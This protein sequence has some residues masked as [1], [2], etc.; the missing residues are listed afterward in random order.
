MRFQRKLAGFPKAVPAKTKQPAAIPVLKKRA[1]ATVA[2]SNAAQP[3]KQSLPSC[4]LCGT[5]LLAV[6][7]YVYPSEV[8]PPSQGAMVEMQ[9][10][11]K[12]NGVAIADTE[13]L[14]TPR[15]RDFRSLNGPVSAASKSMQ[16]KRFSSPSDEHKSPAVMWYMQ[17]LMVQDSYS[18]GVRHA[19]EG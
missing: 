9:T 11:G 8:E 18:Q 14:R 13:D 19:W 15:E 12:Q 17:G 6:A 4:I 1:A 2:A 7:A 3:A 16:G 10:Q 5:G